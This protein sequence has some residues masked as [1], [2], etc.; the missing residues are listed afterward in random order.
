MKRTFTRSLLAAALAAALSSATAFAAGESREK[1]AEPQPTAQAGQKPALEKKFSESLTGTTF[2]GYFTETP[3][4]EAK[5]QESK[6]V[7]SKVSKLKDDL[8]LFEAQIKYGEH[9]VTLPIPLTVRWAGDTPVITL[10]NA[11]IPG[12]GTF[13]ARVLIY[14]NS[15]A[16][17]WSG[18]G[19]RGEL[20]GR[21]VKESE[22]EKGK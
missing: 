15:F 8:W 14:D 4:D 12:I 6:Y 19:H 5:P 7:I 17:M 10:D 2:D 22:K 11:G 9:D 20:Y 18:G 3:G 13:T 16:G 1:P 21:I